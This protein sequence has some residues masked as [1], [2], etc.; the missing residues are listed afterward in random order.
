MYAPKEE[1]VQTESQDGRNR[2]K[3]S[4]QAVVVAD[5]AEGRESGHSVEEEEQSWEGENKVNRQSKG[6]NCVCVCIP[7]TGFGFSHALLAFSLC[8]LQLLAESVPEIKY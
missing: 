3:R 5:T 2:E 8:T 1:A 6:N 4:I 7:Y